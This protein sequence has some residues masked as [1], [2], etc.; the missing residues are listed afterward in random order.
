VSESPAGILR[1]TIDDATAMLTFLLR[2]CPCNCRE[3]VERKNQLKNRL[4]SFRHRIYNLGFDREWSLP[5]L[6][7]ATRELVSI[8]DEIISCQNEMLHRSAEA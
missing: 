3:F 1:D 7:S 4:D 2:T 5:E 8:M 6:S